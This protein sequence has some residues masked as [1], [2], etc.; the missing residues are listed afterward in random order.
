MWFFNRKGKEERKV[1]E[2]KE[3]V[4]CIECDIKTQKDLPSDD[5][6]SGKG[7]PCENEYNLVSKCMKDNAGQISACTTQWDSFKLCH[8]QQKDANAK[9]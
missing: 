1:S 4:V 6:L 2:G 3:E 8:Q 7:M 9:R 5:S